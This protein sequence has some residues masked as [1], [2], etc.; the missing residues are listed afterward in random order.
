MVFT[1]DYRM[2]SGTG[3]S[4]CTGQPAAAERYRELALAGA[5][6]IVVSR[7]G[8]ILTDSEVAGLLKP[9]LEPGN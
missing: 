9:G 3:R 4:V 6:S 2:S 1:I 8:V 5:Y 7:N